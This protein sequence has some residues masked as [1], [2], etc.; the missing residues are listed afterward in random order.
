MGLGRRFRTPELIDDGDTTAPS[1]RIIG[2]IPEYGY[3]KATAGPLITRRNGIA[4]M[5]VRCP[6]FAEWLAALG[7]LDR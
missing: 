1:K 6:Q 7:A 2:E 4:T 5:R 3:Q